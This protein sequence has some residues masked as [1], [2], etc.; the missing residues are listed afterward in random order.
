V[1]LRKEA[2]KQGETGRNREKSGHHATSPL[3]SDS[4]HL[5]SPGDVQE[6]SFR[7]DFRAVSETRPRGAMF[8]QKMPQAT[9]PRR[10]CFP[11]TYRPDVANLALYVH[12]DMQY[13]GCSLRP[14]IRTVNDNLMNCATIAPGPAARG[15]LATVI[16][17]SCADAIVA[18]HNGPRSC[19]ILCNVPCVM[20]ADSIASQVQIIV[21]Q[22]KKMPRSSYQ[23]RGIRCALEIR[24]SKYRM[25]RSSSQDRGIRCALGIQRSTM[26]LFNE[27]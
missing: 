5:C 21:C 7:G 12:F 13:I 14:K 15:R 22:L 8:A 25:P 4:S 20:L 9:D 19:D 27:L 17:T 24:L 2:G 23:D 18:C 26:E 16:V 6:G 11:C 3:S 1:W 10:P